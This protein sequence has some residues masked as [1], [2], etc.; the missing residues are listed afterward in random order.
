MARHGRRAVR[1]S[2]CASQGLASV[3]AHLHDPRAAAVEI[4]TDAQAL[5]KVHSV[6]HALAF[7]WQRRAHAAREVA[8]TEEAE[9]PA[10]N[11]HIEALRRDQ[12]CRVLLR[13]A[14][15]HAHLERRAEKLSHIGDTVGAKDLEAVV[16]WQLREG[17]APG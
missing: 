17:D 13:Q 5:A 16:P 7:D 8:A 15:A 9:L 10:C 11:V 12:V 6:E 2:A 1:K 3:H 4:L 14:A